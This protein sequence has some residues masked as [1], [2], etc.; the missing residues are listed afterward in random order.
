MNN[1]TCTHF[2]CLK[3]HHGKGLC[4]SHYIQA[5]KRGEISNTNCKVENC[6]TGVYAKGYCYKHWFQFKLN[7]VKLY[8][9]KKCVAPGCDKNVRKEY[10]SY[11]IRR[12]NKGM[13]LDSTQHELYGGANNPNWKGGVAQYKDHSEFKRQRLVKLK[14][15]GYKCEICKGKATECHHKDK[16]KSNH[17]QN[18]LTALC[19]KCHRSVFHSGKRKKKTIDSNP[20]VW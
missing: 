15:V 10:C 4:K 1:K 5:L 8:Q 2:G 19:R 16:T 6:R 11:H 13:P 7:G 9:S 14:S 12:V 17:R 3:K 20:R 18:N